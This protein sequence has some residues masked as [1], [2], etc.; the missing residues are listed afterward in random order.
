MSTVL[1]PP[2]TPFPQLSISP[3]GLIGL[4]LT[5][6]KKLRAGEG[7][8]SSRPNFLHM[9]FPL[10][11]RVLPRCTS[12]GFTRSMVFAHCLKARLSLVLKKKVIFN[13]AA[14]FTSCYG[15]WI[16][17]HFVLK[18]LC[19]GASTLGFLHQLPVS[20]EATWLLP[21]PDFHRLVMSSLARRANR[22]RPN[23][24]LYTSASLQCDVSLLLLLA[25][26]IMRFFVPKFASF[27]G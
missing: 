23:G 20:Y 5:K 22:K 13:G 6:K 21:R 16:C 7:L 19:H 17:S 1:C 14:G 9:P 24:P 8:P 15:L 18:L 3:F 10:H 12:K 25:T 11:R 27:D 26:F 2:P 4:L